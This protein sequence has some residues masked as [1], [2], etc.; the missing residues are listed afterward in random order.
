MLRAAHK[1]YDYQDLLAGVRLV[2]LLL[3]AAD[4]IYVDEK[5]VPDDRFDDLTTSWASG[6]RERCQFKFTDNA[7]R[8]LP[9]STFTSDARDCKLDR[10]V[11]SAIADRGHAE[12]SLFR[13]V[14]RDTAPDDERLIRALRQVDSPA[15]LIAGFATRR[16]QFDPEE[17][18]PIATA[19]PDVSS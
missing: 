5:L 9:L 16:Y 7:A 6:L 12:Q 2:D 18:W 13:L 14:V 10:L 4:R 11:L 19:P 15:P 17:L 3:G 8:P 1:G